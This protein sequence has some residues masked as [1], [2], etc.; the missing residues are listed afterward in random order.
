MPE[1]IGTLRG[2]KSETYGTDSKKKRIVAID[3]EGEYPKLCVFTM[4]GKG[5]DAILPFKKGDKIRLH[6][7]PQSREYQ[8]KYFTD[9]FA[10]R[11]EKVEDAPVNSPAPK[12]TEAREPR[13]EPEMSQEEI[14]DLP[15]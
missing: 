13:H 5:V 10:Y 6:F 9:N 2:H 8:G 15:F 7:N 3:S 12:R 4:M 14:D 11:V 1:I